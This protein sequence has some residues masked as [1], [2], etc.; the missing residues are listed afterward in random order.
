MHD[1]LMLGLIDYSNGDKF[2]GQILDF[3]P[4]SWGKFTDPV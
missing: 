4:H 1:R 3:E 2:H